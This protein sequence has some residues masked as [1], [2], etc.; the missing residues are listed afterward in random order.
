MATSL[1]Y[2]T[3]ILAK[4]PDIQEKVRKEVSDTIS[5]TGSLEY[6]VVINKL[7]YLS[8]V[9]DETLR[10]YPPALTSITREAKEDFEYNGTK[11]KAGTCFMIPQY[12]LQ[13]DP[14]FWPSPEEI[15]PERVPWIWRHIVSSLRPPEAR[16]SCF[17]SYNVA[18]M[19]TKV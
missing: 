4:Y 11:F 13:M 15:D 14:R 16:G 19:V 8:Q 2:V 7:N 6:E 18:L 3:F 12:H 10:R 17:T 9:I 1:S 5:A